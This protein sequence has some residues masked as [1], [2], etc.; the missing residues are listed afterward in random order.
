MP[1]ALRVGVLILVVATYKAVIG[2]VR[3]RASS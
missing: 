3:E 2:E 1:F